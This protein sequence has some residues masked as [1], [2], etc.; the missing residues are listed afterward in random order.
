M[1]LISTGHHAYKKGANF[2]GFYEFDEAKIWSSLIAYYIGN[3]V[4]VVPN[5]VLKEKVDFINSQKDVSIAVE[6]HFNSAQRKIGEKTIVESDG[7]EVIENIYERIGNGCETLHYPDSVKGIKAAKLVQSAMAKVFKP[8]RGIK[9]GYFR[10][11]SA[12][13]VDYFLA[14]TNCVSLIIEPEFIHHKDLIQKNR[15]DC[16]AVIAQALVTFSNNNKALK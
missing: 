6:V 16:C 2:E 1:I 13:G 12:N 5:G 10:M 7:S 3:N 8:D 11:D 4:M 9:E 14:R 15:D